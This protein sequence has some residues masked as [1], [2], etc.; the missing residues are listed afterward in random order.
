MCGH[1]RKA[2]SEGC[3]VD[4]EARRQDYNQAKGETL[5]RELFSRQKMMKERGFARTWRERMTRAVCMFRVAKQL[6]NI[7][8]DVVGTNCMKDSARKIVMVEDR[9]M[10]VWRAHYDVLSNEEFTWNRE[11]LTDAR[12]VYGPSERISTLERDAAICKI[13]QGKSSSPINRCCVSDAQG[14][15]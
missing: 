7:N 8:R 12:P 11:D 10:E 9:L 5:L 3:S 2:G 6:V 14:C 4:M 1:G 13:K 15:R